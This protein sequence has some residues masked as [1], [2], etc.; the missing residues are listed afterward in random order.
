MGTVKS[1]IPNSTIKKGQVV[2]AVIVRTK[3]E[4]RRSDGTYIKFN[5]N[6][7]V[8]IKD[9]RDL[10]GTRVFGPIAREVKDAGFN[11]IASLAAEV[12]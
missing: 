7:V 6:A 3:K 5:E 10:I 12:L 1:A 8:L 4:I 9:S 2:K 11:Q